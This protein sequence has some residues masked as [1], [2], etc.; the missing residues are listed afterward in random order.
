[1]VERGLPKP[2]TRVRFPSPA[3]LIPGR[4]RNGQVT[5]WGWYEGNKTAFVAVG[6]VALALVIGLGLSLYLFIREKE[7]HHRAVAAEREQARLREQAEAGLAA[8]AKLR[9]QAELGKKYSEAGFMLAQRRFD[10]AEKIVNEASP[11]PAAASIFSVLGMVHGAREEWLPAIT[12]YAKVV[13]LLP[14]EHSAYHS[15]AAL[16]LQTGNTELYRRHGVEI[17]RRFA[18]TT[19][20]IVAERMAKDC[21]VVAPPASDLNVLARMADIAVAAG[22]DHKYWLSFQFVKGLA[23]YRQ[24][25]FASAV[26]WLQKVTSQEG[27]KYRTVQAYMVLAMAQYQLKQSDAARATLA[28]GLAIANERFPKAGTGGLDD[29]WTDWIFAHTLMREATML[30]EPGQKSPATDQK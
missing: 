11:H 15:L 3:P 26:E 12:N 17:L 27:D 5:R 30:V 9:Q 21:L 29:L 4:S 1:M 8:E 23:E 22:P 28:K 10:E 2:E 19:D 16:R 13:A 20:P 25:R 7:A 6:A 24:G 14:E 18:G